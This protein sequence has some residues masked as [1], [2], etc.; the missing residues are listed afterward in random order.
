MNLSKE[1][2]CDQ[3]SE[4]E[5]EVGE[6]DVDVDLPKFTLDK[7]SRAEQEKTLLVKEFSCFVFPREPVITQYH[8]RTIVWSM[9]R[10]AQTKDESSW[11]LCDLGART[12][13]GM[14]FVTNVSSFCCHREFMSNQTKQEKVIESRV[15]LFLIR[16]QSK[17]SRSSI[18]EQ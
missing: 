2:G 4:K 10:L 12:S 5:G 9:L 17:A 3:L 7:K 18:S 13:S 6:N 16:E 14:S 1:L 15:N 11:W 8:K